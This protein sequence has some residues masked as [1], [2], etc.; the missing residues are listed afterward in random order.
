MNTQ[1]DYYV[2]WDGFGACAQPVYEWQEAMR[3][4]TDCPKC[5]WMWPRW[6]KAIDL[7]LQDHPADPITLTQHAGYHVLAT[8]VWK[9]LTR[10]VPSNE[11]FVGRVFVDEPP[12]PR[13]QVVDLVSYCVRYA[14]AINKHG[15]TGTEYFRCTR[16]HRIRTHPGDRFGY[17]LAKDVSGRPV[18]FTRSGGILVSRAVA[19]VL[20]MA[21]AKAKRYKRLYLKP[22]LVLESISPDDPWRKQLPGVRW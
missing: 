21:Q 10:H 7:E 12:K 22:V 11:I 2:L 8:W 1:G 16:C 13:H 6:H 3:K 15:G 4:K 20:S 5:H 14:S 18:V 17:Y 9:V 19:A